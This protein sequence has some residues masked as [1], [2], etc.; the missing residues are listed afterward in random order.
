MAAACGCARAV[1]RRTKPGGR[2]G[3]PAELSEHPPVRAMP[4]AARPCGRVS[5]TVPHASPRSW[6]PRPRP[7]APPIGR[8]RFVGLLLRRCQPLIGRHDEGADPPA[9][10]RLAAGDEG[11]RVR[12]APRI[13][14][15]GRGGFRCHLSGSAPGPLTAALQRWPRAP[16]RVQPLH[17]AGRPAGQAGRGR[18]LSLFAPRP[19]L[20]SSPLGGE[21]SCRATAASVMYTVCICAAG[22]DL[23]APV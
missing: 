18:L 5:M 9:R 19:R 21:R 22:W 16:R 15:G 1:V 6:R 13:G 10:N 3:D 20:P 11:P 17:V 14:Q 8:P 4:S 12:A 23:L 2:R 7:L